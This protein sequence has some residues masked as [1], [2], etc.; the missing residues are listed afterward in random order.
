MNESTTHCTQ[1]QYRMPCHVVQLD[2]C[3]QTCTNTI[4]ILTILPPQFAFTTGGMYSKS[5]LQQGLLITKATN[6]TMLT[7]VQITK[8]SGDNYAL[9]MCDPIQHYSAGVSSTTITVGY[10]LAVVV[11]WSSTI[12]CMS[13]S[14]DRIPAERKYLT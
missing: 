2:H 4:T 10:L 7:D 12:R 5:Q 8:C 1:D 11:S 6:A 3:Y 14:G 13:F 9:I